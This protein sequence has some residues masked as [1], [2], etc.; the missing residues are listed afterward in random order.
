M[1]THIIRVLSFAALLV[2][3]GCGSSQLSSN[4]EQA[5][6]GP[7]LYFKR[8]LVQVLNPHLVDAN[9]K[10]LYAAYLKFD[11][12]VKN[13]GGKLRQTSKGTDSLP[14]IR[15]DVNPTQDDELIQL[16]D[17]TLYLDVRWLE[18][19]DKLSPSALVGHEIFI[20]TDSCSQ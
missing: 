1:K 19:I 12:P 10:N 5:A 18:G 17:D 2:A 4:T 7:C 8:T 11:K 15:I 16:G 9:D 3:T 6:T 14:L 13:F 20:E